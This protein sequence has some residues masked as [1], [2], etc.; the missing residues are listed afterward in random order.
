MASG[1][2]ELVKQ[3]VDLAQLLQQAVGEQEEDFASAGL[4][5][6][7]NVN[8]QPIYAYVDG[9]KWWRAIDNLIVNARK[10]SLE[11]TRVYV[12]LEVVARVAEFTVKNI[13]KYELGENIEELN[14]AL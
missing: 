7:I 4:D 5:L 3:R 9:Q 14:G 10:Y 8:E 11:G 1:N 6:R 2:V 12:S 13:A